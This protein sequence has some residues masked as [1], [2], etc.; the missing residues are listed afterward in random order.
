VIYR[1][2]AGEAFVSGMTWALFIGALITATGVLVA[3]RFM[4]QQVERVEE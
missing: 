2:V 4:P 1:R 3:W